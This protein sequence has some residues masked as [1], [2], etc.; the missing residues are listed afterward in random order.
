[1]SGR[2]VLS[3]LQYVTS[4]LFGTVGALFLGE[5]FNMCVIFFYLLSAVIVIEKGF[6]SEMLTNTLDFNVLS[7][8]KQSCIDVLIRAVVFVFFSL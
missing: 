1:M 7:Y 2:D 4:D 6:S 3:V 5:R 8:L